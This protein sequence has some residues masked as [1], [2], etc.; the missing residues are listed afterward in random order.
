MQTTWLNVACG[1]R[2]ERR[3]ILS[4]ERLI[5]YR[6]TFPCLPHFSQI[7]CA[8]FLSA[9]FSSYSLLCSSPF[10]SLPLPACSV[11]WQLL[12]DTGS[13]SSVRTASEPLSCF[14]SRSHLPCLACLFS[15]SN[16]LLC[17]SHRQ[18]RG[19]HGQLSGHPGSFHRHQV[20]TR[21]IMDD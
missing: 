4:T 18:R 17:C 5:L 9:L 8:V 13:L 7:F 20:G 14:C 10:P 11:S 3:E 1:M 21:A 12:S 6:I 19:H 16:V 2:C 15:E